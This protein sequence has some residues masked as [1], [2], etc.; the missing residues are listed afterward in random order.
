MIPLTDVPFGVQCVVAALL[1]ASGLLALSAALGILRYESFF[2]R[3]HPPALAAT[4]GTWCACAA[5]IA[6]FSALGSRPLI[7]T[8]VIPIL[9]CISVPITTLFLARAALFRLREAGADVPAPL[10]GSAR[11]PPTHGAAA[12]NSSEPG[13]DL[14]ARP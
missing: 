6:W 1:V 4:L 8:W 11:V 13:Q 2:Q 5:S 7:H 9:L 12:S 3:M 14:P 10:S